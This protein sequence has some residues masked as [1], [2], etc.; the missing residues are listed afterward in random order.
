MSYRGSFIFTTPEMTNR[1][2][3][4]FKNELYL[5]CGAEKAII[6]LFRK[7]EPAGVIE[8]GN[9]VG[10]SVFCSMFHKQNLT[11]KLEK[12]FHTE[13]KISKT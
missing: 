7:V 6:D 13:T 1:G 2:I 10:Q 12:A 4:L 9:V 11:S 5:R 3:D 8:S